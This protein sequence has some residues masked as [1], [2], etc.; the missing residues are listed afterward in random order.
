M[1]HPWDNISVPNINTV[2]LLDGNDGIAPRRDDRVE[3]PGKKG[4][5]NT[6]LK[7]PKNIK[8]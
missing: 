5:R 7:R 1:D 4:L 8:L 6:I 3:E 2:L